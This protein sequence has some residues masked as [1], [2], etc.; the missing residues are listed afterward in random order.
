MGGDGDG[1]VLA[2]AVGGEEFGFG[3]EADGV[4]GGEAELAGPGGEDGGV[5]DAEG[6]GVGPWRA[7]AIP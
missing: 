4:G 6:E 3:D 2:V 1:F 5:D 7:P